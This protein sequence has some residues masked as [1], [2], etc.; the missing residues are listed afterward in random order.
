MDYFTQ[1]AFEAKGTDFCAYLVAL[2]ALQSGL[3]VQF[4]RDPH[5]LEGHSF[6]AYEHTGSVFTVSDGR[7]THVFSRTRGSRTTVKA[8]AIMGDKAVTKKIL[9]DN[10]I[11]CPRGFS[12]D[13]SAALQ[14]SGLFRRL[15]MSRCVVKPLSGSRGD[16][17]VLG[18]D[19]Q[20]SL[21][22]A[23]RAQ[24]EGVG[25]VLIEEHVEGPEFR[26]LVTGK[27]VVAVTK[28]TP[29]NVVGDGLHTI[30]ELIRIK[31]EQRQLNPNLASYPVRLASEV[32]RELRQQ[33][34]TS[35]DFVPRA[36][37]RVYLGGATNLSN[38]GDSE[39]VTASASPEARRIAVAA[40]EAL[41]VPNCGVDMIASSTGGGEQYYVIE[42]NSR[43]QIGSHS[44]PMRGPGQ[45][46][47]VAEELIR[48]YFPQASVTHPRV[49]FSF[50]RV[51]RALRR[52][53]AGVV[54]LPCLAGTNH[55]AFVATTERSFNLAR[56][57]ALRRVFRSRRCLGAV[58]QG[59]SGTLRFEIIAAPQT[60][61]DLREELSER[62]GLSALK[63]M[64]P[65]ACDAAISVVDTD[66]DPLLT[67]EVTSLK[68]SL[69]RV[70]LSTFSRA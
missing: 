10:G 55:R 21:A 34:I 11:T 15:N 26:F 33:G 61:V 57:R 65:S 38:G 12:I 18:V 42:V 51:Q 67:Y 28:R 45:R 4:I 25:G 39:D 49:F 3:R 30:V 41:G 56:R 53:W 14:D 52:G 24:E 1:R 29:P 19:S 59:D 48:T 60:L 63:E 44:F 31:N 62:L 36:E 68:R 50:R 40:A 17:V 32:S 43:P 70:V 54:S 5:A 47:R 22:L 58:T 46:N 27:E 20:E 23:L 2:A 9:A 7:A 8:A 13:R 6:Y 37:Q 66:Y 16:G 35:L 69:K 64:P